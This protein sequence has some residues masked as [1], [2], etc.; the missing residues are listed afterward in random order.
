[1]YHFIARSL[2][3]EISKQK[4]YSFFSD[5]LPVLVLYLWHDKTYPL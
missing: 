2:Y 1:M 3:S 5:M 4:A